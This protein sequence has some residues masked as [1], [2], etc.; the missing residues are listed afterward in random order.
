VWV[1]Q[2]G[3]GMIETELIEA[4]RAKWNA[5]ADEHN[6][7]NDLGCDEKLE[8]AVRAALDSVPFE[9]VAWITEDSERVITDTTKRGLPRAAQAPYTVPLVRAKASEPFGERE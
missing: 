7:W 9:V 2:E 8:L 1:E 5:Q 6:Q 4:T 3:F